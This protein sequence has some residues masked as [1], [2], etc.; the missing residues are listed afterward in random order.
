MRENRTSEIARTKDLWVPFKGK[1]NVYLLWPFEKKLIS[2]LQTPND[3]L[4]Y[5]KLGVMT[6]VASTLPANEVNIFFFLWK[7][8]YY[9]R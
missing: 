6:S 8:R 4:Q 2:I 9:F 7:V 3:A 1:C 5:L